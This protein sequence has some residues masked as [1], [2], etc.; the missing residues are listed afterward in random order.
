MHGIN[1]SRVG[2]LPVIL[3]IAAVLT[4][5]NSHRHEHVASIAAALEQRRMHEVA[6]V[7]EHLAG[8][9]RVLSNASLAHLTLEQ[10]SAR[11]RNVTL[12]QA[13]REQGR[14]PHNVDYPHERRPYFVDD[15]G[16]P[17]AMAYLIASSGRGDL[18]ER[19][20]TSNNNAYV[21]ELAAL[22]EL[23]EWLDSSGLS[24]AEAAR[25][26]PEYDPDLDADYV[27]T[28]YAVVSASTSLL[29]GASIAWNVSAANL[30]APPRW[31]G[32]LGAAVGAFSIGLGATEFDSDGGAQTLGIWNAAVGVVAVAAGAYNLLRPGQPPATHSGVERPPAARGT[33]LTVT[34]VLGSAPGVQ[35]VLAF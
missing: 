5:S 12:L 1:R 3:T 33:A 6:R 30:S 16:V 28:E 35:F 24:L 4:L 34:P 8:A 7:Q 10:Q 17:C 21:R 29:S 15:R 18:V 32:A 20:R 26:Q 31:R 22:P 23:V 13:Y 2:M 14:F 11:S 9:E 27:S 19:I 25:I